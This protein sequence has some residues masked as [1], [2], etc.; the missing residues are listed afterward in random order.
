ML[1]L[2]PPIIIDCISEIEKRETKE[3]DSFYVPDSEMHVE[4]LKLSIAAPCL[5]DVDIYVL[6]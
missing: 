3:L 1:P 6:C 2:V 5:N 4:T